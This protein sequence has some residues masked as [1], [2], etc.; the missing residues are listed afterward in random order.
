VRRLYITAFP[1]RRD[2]YQVPLALSEHGR[3]GGFVT[4]FYR[5]QGVIGRLPMLG[6]RLRARHSDGIAESSVECMELVN[7]AARLGQRVFQPSRVGV[8]EDLAF[9]RRAVALAR[10]RQASLLLYEFQAD[11]AFRQAMRHDAVRILF[12]FHPHPDLE[13][14][15]LLADAE[16]YPQYLDGVRSNT[17][18]NLSS[19]YRQHTRN[20]WRHADHVIVASRFTARSLQSAGCPEDR[21]TVVP[22]GCG[23]SRMA[24]TPHDRRSP[25]ERPYFLYVGSG[26]HRKGLHHLLEAW[27]QSRLSSSHELVVIARVVDRELQGLLA[28]TKSVCHVPGVSATELARWYNSALAFV[29]PSFSEGFGHVYLEA[30]SCGCPVIGTRNSMLPDFAEAQPHIRYVEPGDP[31]GLRAEIERVAE[32]SP[33]DLFFRTDAVRESVKDW[34]FKRFREGLD[35]VLTRYDK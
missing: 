6:A 20:A 22:Y 21:I 16:R 10:S 17:R 11:W 14:P 15:L 18:S 1:G 32:L 8:W 12:Q 28:A 24:D 25:S 27:S 34:T 2:N 4:C 31:E 23:M 30:L 33:T 7:L 29:L 9:A 13:H 26:T 5:G 19:F 3:L 35:S